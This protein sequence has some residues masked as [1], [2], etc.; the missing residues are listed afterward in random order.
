M[1]ARKGMNGEFRG[2]LCSLKVSDV[3]ILGR[4]RRVWLSRPL[5]TD[6]APLFSN[7]ASPHSELSA[8][9]AWDVTLVYDVLSAVS[10]ILS[11]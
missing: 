4:S 7:S 5:T 8:N 3:I 1:V 10:A 6:T 11:S 2:R 9:V